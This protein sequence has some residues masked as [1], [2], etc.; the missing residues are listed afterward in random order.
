M[1]IGA[2]VVL[3]LAVVGTAFMLLRGGTSTIDSVA[4]LPFAT[5][6]PPTRMPSPMASPSA[7]QRARRNCRTCA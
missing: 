2:A 6:A 3:V 1:A 4:V 7:H 5:R